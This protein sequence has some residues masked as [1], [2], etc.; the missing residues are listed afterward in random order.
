MWMCGLMAF[1]C[2]AGEEEGPFA[3]LGFK[4]VLITLMCIDEDFESMLFVLS[5]VDAKIKFSNFHNFLTMA[6]LEFAYICVTNKAPMFY[7]ICDNKIFLLY[8]NP[9]LNITV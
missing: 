1:F 9:V 8:N 4:T 6:S 3:I 7:W 5:T 2:C